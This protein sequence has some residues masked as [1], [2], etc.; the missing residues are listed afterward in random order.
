MTGGREGGIQSIDTRIFNAHPC[1][2]L[3]RI[4]TQHSYESSTYSALVRI[5]TQPAAVKST[6]FP[7]RVSETASDIRD[8]FIV[9]T[10][11]GGFCATGPKRRPSEVARHQRYRAM[12]AQG[13]Q[14][15]LGLLLHHLLAERGL[16]PRLIT[17]P[18]AGAE[19]ILPPSQ[20]SPRRGSASY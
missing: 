4:H 1:A 8:V 17:A 12:P 6:R 15:G 18:K 14:L 10:K 3:R 20:G 13:R 2:S 16:P 11:G 7:S 19:T 5:Q 9:A